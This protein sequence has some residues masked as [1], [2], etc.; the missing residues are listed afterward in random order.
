M[1]SLSLITFFLQ[2]FKST[3]EQFPR[4]CISR[5]VLGSKECCPVWEDG[6][7]CGTRSGR[8]VCE[9]V[10]VSEQPDGPQYPFKGIDDRERWP[11]VFFNRTC[12]CLQNFMGHNCGDCSFGYFGPNCAERRESVRKNIFQ[13]S[14]T[15]R[16]NFIAYLNL[17][18]NTV[19]QD[20]V[21][22]TGTY[23]EII[24]STT[25]MFL[26]VSIYDLFV[27]MHYYVSRNAMLG[28]TNNVWRQVDFGHWAPAFPPWHRVY[29][30]RWEHE[31]RKLT[32]DF[33]F[34]VPYWDWRDARDCD[35]CTDDLM[36]SQSR[37]NPNLISPSSVFSSWKVI[38]SRAPEYSMRGVL[39]DGREEGPLLRNPGKHDRNV[40]DGLPTAANV[41]FTLNLAQYDTG[42]MDVTANMSFRNTLEGFGDP[43]TGLGSSPK[44]GMHASV[45]VFM[46]G[47]MSSVQG[48]AND[49]IFILHHAFVDS[50]YEQWLRRH[51]PD[52]SHYPSAN[53]PIGHNSEYYMAPFIPL[54]R[55]GD[56]FLS[57]KDMGYEY[58]YLQDP[59]QRF[60]DNVASYLEEVRV[61]WIWLLGAA[62]LGALCTGVLA[63]GLAAVRMC[64]LRRRRRPL[65]S[66]KQPLIISTDTEGSSSS[67]SA[68][69]S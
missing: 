23:N 6:S 26:N 27:W 9:D 11:T 65:D 7:P 60:I 57:S 44:M 53:A 25:P 17:A 56:Y 46:N 24:N 40:A 39:C 32:G 38:C 28:G 64:L 47:S 18:K 15:E 22:A 62:V 19:S 61:L 51:Q 8:G 2:L 52:R 66:E 49:P 3:Y 12:R 35:V 1:R 36:G 59:G 67:Y 45:H 4:Q 10:V 5:D 41:E 14:A 16:Q 43:Q 54:Y 50:I 58:A 34:T 30:L 37:L 20:Y 42:D 68:M 48:S 13:L 21:I 69:M 55:N 29:L 31:I 63:V 33:S